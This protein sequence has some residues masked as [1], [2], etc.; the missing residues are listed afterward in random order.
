MSACLFQAQKQLFRPTWM[1]FL[2]Y[3]KLYAQHVL[4]LIFNA[5]KT[6]VKG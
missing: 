3:V 6:T 1:Y 2:E 4:G 5:D